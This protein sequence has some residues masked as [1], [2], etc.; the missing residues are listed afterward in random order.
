[1]N[2][3]IETSRGGGGSLIGLVCCLGVF[4]RPTFVVYSLLPVIYRLFAPFL[5]LV[6][7]GEQPKWKPILVTVAHRA[8]EVTKWTMTLVLT[9]YYYDIVQRTSVYE[10]AELI[11]SRRL[12]VTLYNFSG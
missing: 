10:L 11:I 2:K 8:V 12:V 4:N 3:T 5:Q 1:M 9:V 7:N 6:S